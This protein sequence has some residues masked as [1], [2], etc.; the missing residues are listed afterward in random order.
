VIEEKSVCKSTYY[1][2][3]WGEIEESKEKIDISVIANI[4]K[5]TCLLG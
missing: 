1:Q 4:L 5:N 3:K 2:N